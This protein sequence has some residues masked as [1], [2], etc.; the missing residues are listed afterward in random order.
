MVRAGR[1]ALG[2]ALQRLFDL[3]RAANDAGIVAP[4]REQ[5]VEP[6]ALNVRIE[7]RI[8]LARLR[9]ELRRALDLV[10]RAAALGEQVARLP[11]VLIR[12]TLAAQLLLEPAPA[13]RPPPPPPREP[14]ARELDVVDEPDLREAIECRGDR[15]DVEVLLL[16]PPLE[17]AACASRALEQLERG[18]AAAG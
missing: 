4:A 15:H 3:E 10:G 5:R 6:L 11:G 7:L 17:V 9:D 14:C 12:D 13:G 2:A 1:S 8:A 16:Q 18:F